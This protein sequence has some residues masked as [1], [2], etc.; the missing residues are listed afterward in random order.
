[1]R[2]SRI[3][4]NTLLHHGA[5]KSITDDATERTAAEMWNDTAL[6]PLEY[7]QFAGVT[8]DHKS[9]FH[10]FVSMDTLKLDE[11]PPEDS[12]MLDR[13]IEEE[14][15]AT[16]VQSVPS[17]CRYLVGREEAYRKLATASVVGINAQPSAVARRLRE[18]V[19]D[20]G[21][22]WVT[23]DEFSAAVLHFAAAVD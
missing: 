3:I 15:C 1:M 5:D 20:R 12:I 21:S 6:H 14:G 18:L 9:L 23:F 10:W 2:G 7:A 8:L 4:A 16:D 13:S 11:C 22:A 17:R 19:G